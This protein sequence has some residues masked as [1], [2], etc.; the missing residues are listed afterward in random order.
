MAEGGKKDEH[1]TSNAQHRMLNEKTEG[2]RQLVD[3]L[4]ISVSKINSTNPIEK[5]TIC[6]NSGNE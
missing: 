1:R 4:C 3:E 2:G 5:T 6:S